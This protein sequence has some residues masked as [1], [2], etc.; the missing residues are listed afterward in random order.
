MISA[1]RLL[2]AVVAR[3]SRRRT[4]GDKSGGRSLGYR[5]DRRLWVSLSR[6]TESEVDFPQAAPISGALYARFGWYAPHIFSIVGVGL[7]LVARLLVIEQS[8]LNVSPGDVEMDIRTS[9]HSVTDPLP[10]PSITSPLVTTS[11][12]F[13]SDVGPN[14]ISLLSYNAR[15]ST[16][17]NPETSGIEESGLNKPNIPLRR[18]LID[19]AKCPRGA[20]GFAMT[21]VF[22]LTLGM[23]DS[24]SDTI[25]FA[26]RSQLIL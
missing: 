22:G 10:I 4:L 25:H 2:I 7:D 15:Y 14:S 3:T 13:E 16:S 5:L 8:A 6:L 11:P 20:S 19:M 9:D 21:F 24:T 18:I 17:A 26:Q 12:Q 1:D 23:Q